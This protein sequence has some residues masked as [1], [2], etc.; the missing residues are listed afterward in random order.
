MNN[1]TIDPGKRSTRLPSWDTPPPS[2]PRQW[3]GPRQFGYPPIRHS[4][5]DDLEQEV[6][7]LE[8][9]VEQLERAYV[10]HDEDGMPR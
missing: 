1:I 9:R 2:P 6:R 8:R 5:T 4:R 3:T 7:R 10:W